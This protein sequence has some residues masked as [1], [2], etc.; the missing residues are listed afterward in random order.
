MHVGLIN[1]LFRGG[2]SWPPIFSLGTRMIQR[3]FLN[4][5]SDLWL[6]MC[7]CDQET[8]RNYC[9]RFVAIVR[10]KLGEGSFV[11]IDV[12]RRQWRL[13]V[14]DYPWSQSET[15]DRAGTLKKMLQYACSNRP[16]D[17]FVV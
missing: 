1:D 2:P 5:N 4:I 8:G 16:I 9:A 10:S 6:H 11:L 15:T 12:P 14:N 17:E 7:N 13:N 3:L